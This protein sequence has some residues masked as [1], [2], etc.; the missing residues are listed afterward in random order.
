M[1]PNTKATTVV[2]GN[3]TAGYAGDGGP[4]VNAE[5]RY[6]ESLA[7]DIAGNLYIAELGNDRVRKLDG[8]GSIS[9]VTG[10]GVGGN[11]GDGGP[12]VNA[13]VEPWA[14]VADA[15]GDLY[16]WSPCYRPASAPRGSAT[17]SPPRK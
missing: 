7:L 10:N 17:S 8:T 2:A 5:L 9:T 16:I 14:V 6:P 13:E 15:A 4:A 3:G 1:D 12:A 11:T